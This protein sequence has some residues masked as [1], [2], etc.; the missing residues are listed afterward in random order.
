[1]N[2]NHLNIICKEYKLGCLTSP[3]K[4]VSGGLLHSMWRV[5]TNKGSYAIKQLSHCFESIN[6][7]TI[8]KYELSER[9]AAQFSTQGIPAVCAFK[10][11][12]HYTRVIDAIGYLVYPWIN[13]T[14]KTELCILKISAILAKMHRINLEV[15]EILAPQFD[16]YPNDKIIALADQARIC[17]CS[18]AIDLN[19]YLS[20]LLLVNDAYY[21]AL[22]SLKQ[23]LVVS[24]GDIH[25]KNVLWEK[26]DNPLFIDWELAGKINPT[27]EII[28][29][30][31]DWSDITAEFN[32]SLFVKMIKAYIDA[33]GVIE[34]SSLEIAFHGVFGYWFNWIVYNIERA[35]NMQ[36]D[37][38]IQMGIKQVTLGIFTLLRLK[39]LMPKLIKTLKTSVKIS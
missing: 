34:Y 39:R 30:S 24:H 33:G 11:N 20:E 19:Q 36:N 13:A 6:D 16:F 3:A 15:P 23:H 7:N 2:K 37:Q 17:G 8:Q 10:K 32:Q 12:E 14:E 25:Q 28:N 27:Y 22:P 4:N 29:A 21:H 26:S 18:F 31:L 9:I 1:M 38:Q 35:C 5:N